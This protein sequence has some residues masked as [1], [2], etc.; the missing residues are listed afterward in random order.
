[1]NYQIILA[2]ASPRRTQLLKTA[3]I[4][5]TVRPSQ[6]EE[7][8]TSAIPEQVVEEL[9]RQKAEDIAE[10][11]EDG[12]I[13]IGADTVVALEGQIMGKPSSKEDAERM[14]TLLSG[15]T[16]EV[17]TGVTLIRKGGPKDEILTFSDTAQVEMYPISQE[18]M[19]AYIETGEP[20]DK[21][22]AY[23]IQGRGMVFVRR[24]SGDYNTVVGLP[25]ARVY[26]ELRRLG[27]KA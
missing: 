2:S 1:M 6:K 11:A 23:A 19:Q 16:H 10:H 12:T 22:G 5:H 27:W 14:L 18:E 15:K 17:S 24:I 21:A 20:M 8:L 9:S 26:H 25:V 13:V 3:G 7:I 4:C